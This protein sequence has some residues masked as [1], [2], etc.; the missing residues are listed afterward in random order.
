M[1]ATNWDSTE[2]KGDYP[3]IGVWVSLIIT[4]LWSFRFSFGAL[5]W[6]P[7]G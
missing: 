2:V 5:F 7:L 4:E 6:S 3:D 1:V